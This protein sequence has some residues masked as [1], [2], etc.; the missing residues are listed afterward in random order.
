MI[1]VYE[2]QEVL[3]VALTSTSTGQHSDEETER[4]TGRNA[5]VTT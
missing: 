1:V 2:S 5:A 4:H 3:G